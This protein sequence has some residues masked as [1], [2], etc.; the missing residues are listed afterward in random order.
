MQYHVYETAHL[1]LAPLRMAARSTKSLLSQ[2]WNPW[3]GTFLGRHIS[4]GCEV[5][6][7]IT[8]RYGKPEFDAITRQLKQQLLNLKQQVGVERIEA[9]EHELLRRAMLQ[10]SANERIEIL[11]ILGNV[12]SQTRVAQVIVT[13]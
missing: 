6:E 9:R 2:P 5:F 3:G 11:D 7:N 4:A 12:V 13:H 1:M 8:R 10:W